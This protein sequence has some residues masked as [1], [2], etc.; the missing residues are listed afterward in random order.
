MGGPGEGSLRRTPLLV[1]SAV[2]LLGGALVYLPVT[3]AVWRFAAPAA[4]L[5]A[6]IGA[7]QLLVGGSLLARPNRV[8]AASGAASAFGFVLV[9]L[10]TRQ[11]RVVPDP[12]VPLNSVIGFT[13]IL[14]LLLEVVAGG[15]LA[16]IAVP[17]PPETPSPTR[18]FVRRAIGILLLVPVLVV[19]L[20]IILIGVFASTDGFV[21]AGFPGERP[22]SIAA[23]KRAAVTRRLA[24][25]S[26][27]P[28]STTT[29]PTSACP[30]SSCGAG[31]NFGPTGGCGRTAMRC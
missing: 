13:D 21:G 26:T 15:S 11:V 1:V 9:W 12:W 7:A 17:A 8:G 30:A 28:A 6:A 10:I 27:F 5:L 23:A 14:C 18:R 2:A 3:P 24:R 31:I 19:V 29:G 25:S 4:V 16:A 20:L 22:G